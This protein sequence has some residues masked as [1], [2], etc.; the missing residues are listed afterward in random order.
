MMVINLLLVNQDFSNRY[1][2]STFY[3]LRRHEWSQ[4]S[5]RYLGGN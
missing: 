4:F 2:K 3:E 1:D 5:I